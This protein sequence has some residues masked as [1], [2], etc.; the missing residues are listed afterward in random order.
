M[1]DRILIDEYPVI[2]KAKDAR[3]DFLAD[4]ITD[5]EISIGDGGYILNNPDDEPGV[6]TLYDENGNI[7][8]MLYRE[9]VEKWKGYLGSDP[10]PFMFGLP[11]TANYE[12]RVKLLERFGLMKERMDTKFELDLDENGHKLAFTVVDE[13]DGA[14]LSFED[15]YEEVKK[16]AEPV[17]DISWI[18]KRMKCCKNPMERKQLEKQLNAAYKAK[19]KARKK[20]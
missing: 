6:T 3:R 2:D 20:R 17:Y 14:Y 8:E 19:K 18:R 11:G 1:D 15:F 9:F 5:K 7:E 4:K 13:G 10:S 12:Y 16:Q